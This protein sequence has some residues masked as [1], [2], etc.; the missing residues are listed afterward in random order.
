MKKIVI[1]MCVMLSLFCIGCGAKKDDSVSDEQLQAVENTDTE[2][3]SDTEAVA[4]SEMAF[5]TED[6]SEPESTEN[7]N[8]EKSETESIQDEIAKVESKSV[9]YE[10]TDMSNMGQ[11]D[12]NKLTSDWYQLWDDELNSLWSR[13][14][15]ELDSETK[16]KALEEQR[17]WVTEKE[18]SIEEAGESVQGG[19]L[20]SQV[21]NTVAEQKTRA[22]AYVL[23]GYLAKVRNEAFTTPTDVQ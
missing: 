9:E 7:Q 15:K 4:D 11:Q 22:R 8:T 12:I 16:E 23:A 18:A 20:Q 1:L 2:E 3:V 10:N 13:L 14:N 19:S 5:A 6:K 21:E 17:A